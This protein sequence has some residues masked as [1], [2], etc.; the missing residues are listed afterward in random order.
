M[1]ELAFP[2]PNQL[3][4]PHRHVAATRE[5][6]VG[7]RPQEDGRLRIGGREGIAR[8]V[9]SHDQ[10]R[11]SL[12]IL[13][14]LFAEA[15][16]LGYSVGPIGGSYNHSAGVA[17]VI[18]GHAYAIQLSELTDRFPL[19]GEDLERWRKANTWRSSFKP[20][21]VGNRY[22]PNGKL[23]LTSPTSSRGARSTWSEGPRGDLSTKLVSLFP[24]LERR[25]EE[26]DRRN[27]EN[28]RRRKEYE[29]AQG[30]RQARERR[31]RIEQARAER[32]AQEVTAWRLASAG[33]EYIRALRD[34]LQGLDED[35]RSRVSA[36]CKWAEGWIALSDPVQNVAQVKGLDD[37]HDTAGRSR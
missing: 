33:R 3:R 25:A 5:A 12:L 29:R 30:E 24:E 20:G 23:R 28:A 19:E 4:R 36:W 8:L 18:R 6:A 2:I 21:A 13:Q 9:V 11:R 35:D 17:I 31:A 37:E 32:L 1:P 26:D 22:A 10:L 27:E 15:E 14:G 16:R 7:Q 34:R